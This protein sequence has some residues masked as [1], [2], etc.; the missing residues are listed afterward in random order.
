MY[1]LLSALARLPLPLLY[2][3]ASAIQPVLMYVVRYRRKVVEDNIAHAFPA[4]DA[5]QRRILV[6]RFYQHFCN[7]AME[8]LRGL[9]M[10]PADIAG[11]MQ[12][13]NWEVLEP[14]L[15]RRQSVLFLTLHQGN[16]EW[17][18]AA[19]AMR[20]PCPID[21]IYKPLHNQTVD[22]LMQASRARFG[23]RP[24]AFQNT[25]REMLRRRREFRGFSL[26]ADQAPFKKDKHS[27]HLFLNRPAAFY[28]G[29]QK[30]AEA[31]Q[32]P[33]VF[34]RVTRL[35]RGYYEAHFEILAEPPIERGGTAVLEAYVAAAERAI[36][37]QPETWLWSNRKWKHVPPDMTSPD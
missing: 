29:P 30:I 23:S 21:A 32:Y 13:R 1:I 26:V 28:L 25:I 18:L 27:W 14:F 11:R 31:T 12:L 2:L 35:R 34:V 6:R 10:A 37:A 3:L 5:R 33:V 22:R 17:L 19:M 36:T 7:L 4:L 9:R 15:A 24:I 8:S 20:L 16:W